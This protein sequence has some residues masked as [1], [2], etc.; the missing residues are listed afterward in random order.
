MADINSESHPEIK[1]RDAQEHDFDTIVRSNRLEQ[2]NTSP[3]DRDRLEILRKLSSYLK[4]AEVDHQVAGFLLAM[5][6]DANYENTNFEWFAARYQ[7]FLYIDR[8]VVSREFSGKK[9]G[10]SLYSNLFSAARVTSTKWVVCEYNVVPL[11]RASRAFHAKMGFTEVG[12]QAIAE[13]KRI[14][15]QAKELFPEKAA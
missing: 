12:Q 7:N 13:G 14:S 10:S 11:N 15:L 8:I 1:L 3:M 4:V 9:I 2:Q 5:G 6:D